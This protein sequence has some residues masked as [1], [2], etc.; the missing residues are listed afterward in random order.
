MATPLSSP[1][2]L[3][4]NPLVDG[5]LSRGGWLGPQIVWGV[6]DNQVEGLYW[7]NG[8]ASAAN[9]SLIFQ[10]I[11]DVIAT[12]FVYGGWWSN[13]TGSALDITITFTTPQTYSLLG[14]SSNS[15]GG[16]VYPYVPSGAAARSLLGYS[17]AQWPQ[18]EGDIGLNFNQQSNFTLALPGNFAWHMGLKLGA[19]TLGLKPAQSAGGG[20]SL[21]Y[22]SLGVGEYDTALWTVMS[23][24]P[25]YNGKYP[26]TLM[27]GDI[28]A[29]QYLYGA[30]TTTFAGDTVH[31][32]VNDGLIRSIYDAGGRDTLDASGSNSS[33]SIDLIS[34]R[35]NVGTESSIVAI[36]VGV[37]IEEVIGSV[38]S[39]RIYG[40]NIANSLRG[41][42]GIDH[43]S[44]EGGDDLLV[45][46]RG[47][48]T[49]IGGA[50]VD[51]A[52]Y[53][54]STEAVVVDL[55]G[56][57][58][59][60]EAQGD[61]I[62]SIE[63]LSGSS[64]NDALA[65]NDLAN[66]LLGLDG[67]DFLLGRGGADSL[68]GGSGNDILDGGD[69]WDLTTN[70]R[71]ILRLYE[72]TLDRPPDA[73]GFRSWVAALD[74]GQS[75]TSIASGFVNSVEF[76]NVYGSLNNTQFVTLLYNNVL[77]RSPDIAGL[78]NWVSALSAGMSRAE[79]VVGFSESQEFKNST[80]FDT[81]A[82]A[83]L[84]LWEPGQIYRLYF[85]TLNRA[86]DVAGFENWMGALGNGAMT[87]NQVVS[88]FVYS[89]EFQQRYGATSDTQFVTL[90]YNNVLNRPPDAGG[91]ASWLSFLSSGGTREQV[92]IGFS[93]S[94]EFKNATVS[95][96]F[97]FM[98]FELSHYGDI[99][100]GG[101][102]NDVLVGGFGMDLF[103][104]NSLE[105][106]QK[107]VY[108]LD[109]FD[110]LSFQ[111]FGYAN[112]AAALTHFTQQGADLMFSDQGV[113]IFFHNTTLAEIA[114]N[115]FV[116]AGGGGG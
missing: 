112:K 65:G 50:G 96:L 46:G 33:V 18:P 49:L 59:G 19:A 116:L 23:S 78:N 98:Q 110:I 47:A 76:Q 58:S 95:G 80:V 66:V 104:F 97:S 28:L 39:D 60:G 106:G 73:A 101:L 113:S 31:Q 88:N 79:V 40:N 1:A 57:A 4:L 56:T 21:T 9:I 99:L 63:N 86:P 103:S 82:F 87:F 36:A 102:G 11:S 90:L 69:G 55:L 53:F 5:L 71:S 44:G 12:P 24:I 34:S 26:S 48:D 3:S 83:T 81:R 7:T 91:L 13:F 100:S 89:V 41:N 108:G 111:G 107:V 54:S 105:D 92:V 2:P 32:I 27:P 61:M 17:S 8:T 72:A 67:N 109:Q 74:G 77:D 30:D 37:V 22:A 93:E 114:N 51:E 38:W 43:L 64:F 25:T 10:N 15:D 20:N 6:A 70:G 35:V 94:N 115:P 16:A 75:L 84:E 45:G 62:D 14:F 68:S 85:A 52:S 29:L 42:D